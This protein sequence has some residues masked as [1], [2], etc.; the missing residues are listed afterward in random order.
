[1]RRLEGEGWHGG[2]RREQVN[3]QDDNDGAAA[4]ARRIPS[5]ALPNKVK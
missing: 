3:L 2:K 5:L 1:M 4:S